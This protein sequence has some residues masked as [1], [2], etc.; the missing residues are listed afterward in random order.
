MRNSNS[1]AAL[2]KIPGFTLI[3]F[4]AGF[5]VVFLLLNAF[6]GFDPEQFGGYIFASTFLGLI[7]VYCMCFLSFYILDG[8]V[9]LK[10]VNFVIASKSIE[11]AGRGFIVNHYRLKPQGWRFGNLLV[12]QNIFHRVEAGD[13]VTA[14]YKP[15]T[16]LAVEIVNSVPREF[17]QVSKEDLSRMEMVY[18]G[19]VFLNTVL[20]TLLGFVMFFGGVFFSAFSFWLLWTVLFG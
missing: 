7:F 6:A 1:H 19:Q 15:F 13:S 2:S 14:T 12:D 4:I 17:P 9:A 10:R 18:S 8:L 5:M 16:K 11:K 3:G 20:L